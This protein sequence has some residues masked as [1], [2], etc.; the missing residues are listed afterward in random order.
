MLH[1]GSSADSSD[2]S[3]QAQWKASCPSE[4]IKSLKPFEFLLLLSS[5]KCTG[6]T[7]VVEDFVRDRVLLGEDYYLTTPADLRIGRESLATH[8]AMF[9]RH[10]SFFHQCF[11]LVVGAWRRTVICALLS[12]DVLVL[13][14]VCKC[15][16]RTTR[17]EPTCTHSISPILGNR[18]S[19]GQHS[20]LDIW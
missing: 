3:F 8:L 2:S 17:K 20:C 19:F 6:S 15:M 1:E 12:T 9:I 5:S 13:S 16:Q 11:P 18:T 7:R 14:H 4:Y 10:H